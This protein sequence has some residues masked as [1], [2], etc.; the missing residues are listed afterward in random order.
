MHLIFFY[1]LSLQNGWV[2]H[3]RPYKKWCRNGSKMVRNV[4]LCT[5]A[6]FWPFIGKAYYKLSR[7]GLSFLKSWSPGRSLANPCLRVCGHSKSDLPETALFSL[8]GCVAYANLESIVFI[9]FPTTLSLQTQT[10]P[11]PPPPMPQI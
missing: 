7:N 10:N 1:L 11:N 8:L 3:S 9:S 4:H 2:T 5:N 6:L